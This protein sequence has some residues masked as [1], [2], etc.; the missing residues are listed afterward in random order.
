M[1]E[2]A[3]KVRPHQ[4]L[5]ELLKETPFKLLDNTTK[6]IPIKKSALN[7]IGIGEKMMG[8][9]LPERAFE[10]YDRRYPGIVMAHNPDCISKLSSYPG[11][12]ILC[13]HTHGA[14]VNLP[15]LW[16]KFMLLEN[17]KFKRGLFKE[18][19]KW[20]YVNRGVGSTMPFRWFSIPEIT[21]ITLEGNHE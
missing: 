17:M 9:C 20:V 10:G 18:K 8:K 14:Q 5:V 3:K 12:V 19:E 4:E 7:L 6:V 13:G 21:T 1:T 2:K 15:F 11:D 16:K